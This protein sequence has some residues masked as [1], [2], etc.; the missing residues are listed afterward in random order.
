[1]WYNNPGLTATVSPAG[2]LNIQ[3]KTKTEKYASSSFSTTN[4]SIEDVGTKRIDSAGKMVLTSGGTFE[5]HVSNGNTEWI[6]GDDDRNVLGTRNEIL[7][8]GENKTLAL[9]SSNTTLLAGEY[10]LSVA[11]GGINIQSSLP[12]TLTSATSI[13]MTA[14]LISLLGGLVEIGTFLGQI[15]LNSLVVSDAYGQ[16]LSPVAP[17]G[18]GGFIP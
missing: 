7:V 14:P 13:V 10:I 2:D 4:A 15:G 17:P 8:G 11:L 5:K 9:G 1:M 3:G 18:S 12:L 16:V 6:G